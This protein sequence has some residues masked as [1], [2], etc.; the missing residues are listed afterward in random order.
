MKVI[1]L[2]LL[3]AFSSA[4][5]AEDL[6]VIGETFPIQ[7]PD[8]IEAIQQR[9]EAMQDSGEL[10]R[11][12]DALRE[13]S[14]SYARRPEGVGLP[15]AVTYRARPIDPSFTLSQD[16]VD[17]EGRVLFAKGLKINPLKYRPL[18]RALCF[19]DGDDPLQVAW[20]QQACPDMLDSKVI[21]VN[22]DV[23]EAANTLQRQVFFDQKA[24]LVTRFDVR[25]VPAVV[26]QSG[27]FLYVE[28]FPV[29]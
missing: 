6:G 18:T 13:K 8:M 27:D 12:H 1:L 2:A 3:T 16:I 5:L 7:E 14:R 23:L 4:A 15:R 25:A 19:L 10:A 9:L 28:E 20:S 24:L 29:E 22:G 26:R 21:L 17:A 11:E